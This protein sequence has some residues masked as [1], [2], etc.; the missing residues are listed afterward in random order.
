[1][2]ALHK[3]SADHHHAHGH[4]TARSHDFGSAFA[5][6]IALNMGFILF[7]VAF[8]LIS[9]SVALLADAGHNLGDVLGLIAAWVAYAL[10]R[11]PA[12]E[13][14]TYGLGSATILAALVNAAALL[15]VTGG[16]V[17]EAMRRLADPSPVAGATVMVV[18]AVG[19]LVNGLSAWL[20][21][22]GRKGDLNIRGAF[23]HLAAD[24][25]VSGAVVLAGLLI[26]LTGWLWVDPAAS[27]LLCAVII[28][29]TWELLVDSLKLSMQAVPGGID[30][31]AVRR[32]LESLDGVSRI[33]DLHIWP[34]STAET[35]LTCHLVMPAGHPGD[36]FM[37]SAAALMHDK[38]G[39]EHA[40]FQIEVS[41][42]VARALEGRH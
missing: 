8:G 12:T 11:R 39:V 21:A 7:E 18:A 31:R 24:A 34:M 14:F 27:L 36:A 32:A 29:M 35:A 16:I 17:W 33:H 22:R 15:L 38:F 19:V 3:H 20:F 2:S 23:L 40:T 13:R 26:L 1:M 37:V 30:P 42:D 41:E 4:A 28:F 25:A 6:G 5:I 9:H 10:G